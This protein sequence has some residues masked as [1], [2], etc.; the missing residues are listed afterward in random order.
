MV[1]VGLA[2]ASTTCWLWLL[3]RYNAPFCPHPV[4]TLVANITISTAIVGDSFEICMNALNF[5]NKSKY[6]NKICDG[7]IVAVFAFYKQLSHL[8]SHLIKDER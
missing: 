7:V 3:G 4:S 2:V 6:K 8:I 1:L 5:K